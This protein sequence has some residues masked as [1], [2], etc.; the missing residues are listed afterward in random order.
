MRFG[1]I[2]VAE[3][4]LTGS[5]TQTVSRLARTT[6]RRSPKE[7]RKAGNECWLLLPSCIPYSFAVGK[8]S[9]GHREREQNHDHHAAQKR[10]SQA[11]N[12]LERIGLREGGA[13]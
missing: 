9:V 13:H 10:Q 7:S 2:I 8:L 12:E 11:A 6:Q 3:G 1:D 5:R 4:K